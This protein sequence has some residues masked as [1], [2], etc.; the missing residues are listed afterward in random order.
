MNIANTWAYPRHSTDASGHVTRTSQPTRGTSSNRTHGACISR[1][2]SVSIEQHFY[3]LAS[4]LLLWVAAFRHRHVTLELLEKRILKFKG[5][6]GAATPATTAKAV[7]ASSAGTTI[8][9]ALSGGH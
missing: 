2:W 3:M 1:P 9:A 8:P 7:S 4:P 6:G 5:T